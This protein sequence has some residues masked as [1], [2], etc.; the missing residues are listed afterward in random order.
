[1]RTVSDVIREMFPQ[2]G[3]TSIDGV[4]AIDPEGLAALLKLTGPVS[5]EGRTE[6]LTSKNAARFLLRD[7]YV[8]FASSNPDRIDFLS[9]A[10]KAVT[11]RLTTSSLPGLHDVGRILGRAARGGHLQARSFDPDSDRFL[12][13]LHIAQRLGGTPGDYLG[14]VTQ[15]ASGS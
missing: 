5:V 4:L 7:Q 6:P 8:E 13:A 10:A 9:D 1:F 15:N 14:L 2:S 3:G 11:N 12:R